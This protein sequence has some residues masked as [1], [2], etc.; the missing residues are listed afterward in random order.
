MN[1]FEKHSIVFCAGIAFMILLTY[2][3]I[4]MKKHNPTDKQ[5]TIF[6]QEHRFKMEA[7]E[8]AKKHVDVKPVKF[9]LKR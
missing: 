9:L 3:I 1:N 5:E 4:T 7:R 2:F 6:E 8:L